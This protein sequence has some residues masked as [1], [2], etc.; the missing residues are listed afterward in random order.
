[1][2]KQELGKCKDTELDF[3]T[4]EDKLDIAHRTQEE[5]TR[6][7]QKAQVEAGQCLGTE[8][9][10]K[11]LLSTAEKDLAET[12]KLLT[13]AKSRFVNALLTNS[14][15]QSEKHVVQLTVDLD[16]LTTAE[17]RNEIIIEEQAQKLEEQEEELK[18]ATKF[19]GVSASSLSCGECKDTLSGALVTSIFIRQFVCAGCEAIF[20]E[21]CGDAAGGLTCKPCHS[22]KRHKH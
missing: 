7:L 11:A 13:E 5:L 1:M 12:I 17:R 18:F 19:S 20:H 14:L 22:T 16:E 10:L 15:R 6:D 8:E 2:L 4:L 21:Y 3:A 9:T